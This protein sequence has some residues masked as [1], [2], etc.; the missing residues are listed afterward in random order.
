MSS[1]SNPQVCFII[2]LDYLIFFDC[3]INH[4]EQVS[5]DGLISLLYY[6]KIKRD[7]D[8]NYC[9]TSDNSY[10]ADTVDNNLVAVSRN[11]EDEIVISEAVEDDDVVAE[12]YSDN[13][14]EVNKNNIDILVHDTVHQENKDVTTLDI[15]QVIVNKTKFDN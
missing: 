10:E 8:E 12:E 15:Y 7:K 13:V 2:K 9:D 14:T 6:R 11:V 3:R 1:P 5:D 4:S